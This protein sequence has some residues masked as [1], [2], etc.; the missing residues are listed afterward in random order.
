MKTFGF[1]GYKCYCEDC[2]IKFL[3][4]DVDFDRFCNE[5]NFLI[6]CPNCKS[7]CVTLLEVEGQN[8]GY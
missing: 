4:S 5:T 2:D 3:V 8:A 6:K 1:Q 7:T